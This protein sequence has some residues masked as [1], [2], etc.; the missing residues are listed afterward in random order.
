M[1]EDIT[2]VVAH[3]VHEGRADRDLVRLENWMGGAV[4]DEVELE[5]G[6]RVVVA[7][8]EVLEFGEALQRAR[9][10]FRHDA[11][12]ESV[13]G[14]EAGDDVGAPVLLSHWGM[15]MVSFQPLTSSKTKS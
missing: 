6:E 2:V 13:A 1:I 8:V 5:R 7:G 14:G 3:A 11:A 15:A 10:K 9:R 12:G 4:A